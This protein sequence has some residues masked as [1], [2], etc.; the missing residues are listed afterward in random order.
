MSFKPHWDPKDIPDLTGKV[1]LVTG[2]NTGIG[3]ET[4]YYLASKNATVYL[5]ARNEQRANAAIDKLQARLKADK[6]ENKIYFHHFDLD[7][8]KGVK[9]SAEEFIKKENRLDILVC[10]AGAI[11]RK[12]T[13]EFDYEPAF[14]AN[15][16]G[17]FVFVNTL[18]PLIEKTAAE[19]NDTRIVVTTSALALTAG[20]IDYDYITK[21]PE[22]P[23][24]KRKLGD[25][26]QINIAYGQSKLANLWFAKELDKR[27]RE[28]GKRGIYVNAPHPG[29][30]G[31]TDLGLEAGDIVPAWVGPVVA[32]I[33]KFF[34]LN[35]ADGAATQTYLATS[36]EVPEHDIHGKFFA[37]SVSWLFKYQ[38]PI[39][40][41]LD[42]ALENEDEWRKLW[43][44]SEEAVRKELE[45]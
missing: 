35:P 9:T 20:K 5:A 15:H 17:H 40:K 6:I 22:N 29:W 21:K 31:S 37:P 39:E 38:G 1:A 19:T 32:F 33:A 25:F 13:A 4:V 41:K 42:P 12:W 3:F 44:F 45:K 16:L 36:P 28:Q 14:F 10:N 26:A 11:A 24:E 34:A 2:A 7:N 27:L 30:V 8:I 18:L 43:E 23:D